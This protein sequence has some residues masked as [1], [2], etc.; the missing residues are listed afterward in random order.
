MLSY[1]NENK[2]KSIAYFKDNFE[3]N[4]SYTSEKLLENLENRSFLN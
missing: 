3:N 1:V 2:E 4:E